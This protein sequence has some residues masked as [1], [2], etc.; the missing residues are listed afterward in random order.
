M[1]AEQQSKIRQV[2]DFLDTAKYH[3]PVFSKTGPGVPHGSVRR[4]PGPPRQNRGIS[5]MP[6]IPILFHKMT[7]CVTFSHFMAAFKIIYIFYVLVFCDLLPSA[8]ILF[9]FGSVFNAF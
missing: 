8:V 5:I 3:S 6:L 2:K 9:G 4:D 1:T 7:E